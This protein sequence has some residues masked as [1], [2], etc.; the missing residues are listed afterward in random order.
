MNGDGPGLDR[1]PQKIRIQ[2]FHEEE[3]SGHNR[4]DYAKFLISMT[5]HVGMFSV[6]KSDC[7]QKWPSAVVCGYR[8]RTPIPGKI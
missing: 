8:I 3:E 6:L 5:F 4:D 2:G 7:K 1:W